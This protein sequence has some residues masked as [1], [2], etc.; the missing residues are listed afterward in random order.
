MVELLIGIYAD[1][2]FS[3]NSSI[4]LGS[5]NSLKGR[6]GYLIDSFKWMYKVFDS[7]GVNLIVDLGDLADS[8]NLR[9]EEITAISEA[10]SYG[11]KYSKPEIHLL[12]N[13]ERLSKEGKI[14]SV[15]FVRN[16]ENHYLIDEVTQYNDMTFIPYG[17]YED[18][19]FDDIDKTKYAFSHIDIFG[20]DTGG[21]SLKSGLSPSYLMERFDL[22]LNGHIHNGSWV[23]KDRI[24]N[25]GSLSGQNF[26][27][28]IIN[29]KP[30]VWILNTENK[31]LSRIENPYSLNFYK[32]SF[33]TLA[34]AIQFVDSL[35]SGSRNIVQFTVPLDISDKLREY[36]DNSDNVLT[37]RMIVK[38][39]ES[40]LDGLTHEDIDI[41]S[42]VEGGFRKLNEFIESQESL[43]YD[44]QDILK[45]VAE[46]EQ[47]QL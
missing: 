9:A 15:N 4:L 20:A 10:L 12:G 35:E 25:V 39:D 36:V 22:I 24:L 27:S 40:K 2:H 29:W 6:L 17:I 1:A 32:E 21:W 3:I 18:E 31:A 42:S 46:L 41:I 8:Y 26:S 43:P 5:K 14:N 37:S 28:K 45:V 38:T 16:I 7:N 44:K 11:E 33:D 13:H 23:V 19:C 34:D 47:N 30:S